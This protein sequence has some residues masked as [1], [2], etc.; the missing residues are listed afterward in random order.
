MK[1]RK[2]KKEKKDLY[3]LCWE[4]TDTHGSESSSWYWGNL[5]LGGG[6]PRG[7]NDPTEPEVRCQSLDICIFF[8][9]HAVLL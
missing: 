2:E 9:L 3:C 1:R 5:L 8:S 4:Q 7:T 6:G